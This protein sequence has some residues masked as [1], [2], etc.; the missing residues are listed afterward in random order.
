V[1]EGYAV[2]WIWYLAAL[3]GAGWVLWRGSRF[4]SPVWRTLITLVPVLIALVPAPV[5]PINDAL[6]P[7]WLVALFDGTVQQDGSFW[8]A[9]KVVVFAGLLGLLPVALV[10]W[11]QR[12]RQAGSPSTDSPQ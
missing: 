10:A 11:W 4:L 5:S 12:R 9:G 6:A 1:T 2:A 8:R 7:A 3:A